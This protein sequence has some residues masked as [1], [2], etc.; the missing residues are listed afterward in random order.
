[1]SGYDSLEVL[2]L[3]NRSIGLPKLV[4]LAIRGRCWFA[5]GARDWVGD[6]AEV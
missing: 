4:S 5:E 1:M 6:A 2:G 3:E